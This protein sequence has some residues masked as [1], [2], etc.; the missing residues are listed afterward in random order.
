[1]NSTGRDLRAQARRSPPTAT[2]SSCQN[3][4]TVKTSL[5]Q[6]KPFATFER[7]RRCS[8]RLRRPRRDQPAM[9]TFIWNINPEMAGHN[10]IFGTIGAI[11][12]NCVGQGTPFLAQQKQ[13]HE[14]RDPRLRRHRLVE[15]VRDR[16]RRPASRSTRRRRSCS[17]T[18]S[19]SSRQADLSADVSKMKE[20]GRAVHLHLHRRQRVGDPRQGAREAAR[21]RGA[22]APERLRRRSSCGENAQYLEGAF[23]SPQ[24]QAFEYEPQLAE[25]EALPGVDE[26]GQPDGH[27]A[28][29]PRAGSPRNMF[30]HGLKLAGPEL[31]A[32]EADRLA[33]PG[34]GVRRR[35]A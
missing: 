8:A 28:Q 3:E 7:Q 24:F 17:S 18:T 16:D 26:E 22:A 10:N 4:Q 21:E 2:T 33:E 15:A 23:V 14:G 5:A 19:C 12:F 20:N 13:L 29:R 27:R 9:P 25:A 34:D 31:H 6:D 11:C 32:A 1:M 35:T 30:V